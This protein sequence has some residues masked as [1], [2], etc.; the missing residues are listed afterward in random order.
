MLNKN[1]EWKYISYSYTENFMT[2][3][4]HYLDNFNSKEITIGIHPIKRKKNSSKLF[5]Y[6]NNHCLV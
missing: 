1:V 6:K 5:F 3:T 2:L 4:I